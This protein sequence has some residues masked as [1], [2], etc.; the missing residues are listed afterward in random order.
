M[1]KVS[2]SPDVLGIG[3][4]KMEEIIPY[5]Q[6][7]DQLPHLDSPSLSSELQGTSSV[8]SVEMEFVPDFEEHLESN[9]FSPT[10]AFNVQHDYELSKHKQ[11][12]DT[13][14]DNP[15]HHDTHVSE[16]QGQD[17]FLIHATDLSNNFPLPQFMAQH[18]CEDLKHINT[19]STFSTFTQTFSDHTSNQIVGH[20]E[21][22]SNEDNEISDDLYKFRALTG[23]QG[24]LKA[25]DPNW[26]GCKHKIFVEWKTGET[27]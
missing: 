2:K 15:N 6:F 25:T 12:S 27:T 21:A 7:V 4:G 11:E 22:A 23:N 16:K 5:N 17:D 9:K 19:P 14:S 24:P 8:E 13:P 1:A 20:L 26:K 10:D 3:N 18:N